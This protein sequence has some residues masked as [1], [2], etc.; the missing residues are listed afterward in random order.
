[1]TVRR[2]SLVAWAAVV[3]A[4]LVAGVSAQASPDGTPAQ[5]LIAFDREVPEGESPRVWLMNEHGTNQRPLPRVQRDSRQPRWSPDGRH[6]LYWVRNGG[7]WIAR[8]DGTGRRRIAPHAVEA[9]WA[10]D[11][12]RVVLVGKSTRAHCTDLFSMNLDGSNVRRLTLTRACEDSPSWSPDGRRIAF[13]AQTDYHGSHIVAINAPGSS[14]RNQVLFGK[15][16]APRWS[17]DGKRLAFVDLEKPTI[18]IN[19]ADG[20]LESSL[21]LTGPN[22]GVGLSGFAWTND[23][24]G[25]VYAI[26]EVTETLGKYGTRLYR[27]GLDGTNRKLLT[28]G[29]AEKHPDVQPLR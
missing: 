26:R 23:G 5:R 16:E 11:G 21:D 19:T 7:I 15:G 25:F 24:S 12:K 1:M 10:P 22:L 27:I 13:R 20:T 28:Q 29:D 2:A 4:A 17:P 6:L 9:A 18:H 8:P 3:A 14:S